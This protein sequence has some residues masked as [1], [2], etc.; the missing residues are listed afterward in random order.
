MPR[1]VGELDISLGGSFGSAV[2]HGTWRR[3]DYNQ[4]FNQ[5]FLFSFIGRVRHSIRPPDAHAPPPLCAL[6]QFADGPNH[7]KWGILESCALF[8]PVG[9]AH[10]SASCDGV[11]YAGVPPALADL[12]LM[13][14]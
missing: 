13:C 5:E 6:H 9:L 14:H 8:L 3:R 2:G 12:S 11:I 10:A 1:R 7:C 4:P